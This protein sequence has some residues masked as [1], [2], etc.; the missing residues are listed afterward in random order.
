MY[1]KDR[2]KE[3]MKNAQ[4]YYTSLQKHGDKE[5]DMKTTQHL[6]NRCK[7]VWVFFSSAMFHIG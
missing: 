4:E 5:K 2:N 7:V 6:C 3:W 1:K